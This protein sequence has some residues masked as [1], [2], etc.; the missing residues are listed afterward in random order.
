MGYASAMAWV[1]LL[2][3]AGL[4]FISFKLSSLWVFYET[5]EG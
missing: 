1:M 4:T 5:K 3:I 2:I